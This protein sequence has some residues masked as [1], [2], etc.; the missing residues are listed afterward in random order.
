LK[1]GTLPPFIG[2]RIK[3]FTQELMRRSVRTLDIFLTTLLE[4]AGSCR[5][6]SS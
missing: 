3:P 1:N 5:R 4:K 6:T 2:I